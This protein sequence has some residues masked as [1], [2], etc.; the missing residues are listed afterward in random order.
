MALSMNDHINHFLANKPKRSDFT[1]DQNFKSKYDICK[2]FDLLKWDIPVITVVGTNGKGSCVTAL[3]KAYQAAGYRTGVMTSPHIHRYNERIRVNL[4]E[5]SDDDFCAIAE[6]MRG[7]IDQTDLTFALP[8][9]FFFIGLEYFKLQN[10]DVLIL[11]AGM[12][13]RYDT[14]NLLHADTIIVSSISLDHINLLGPSREHIGYEK[15]GVFRTGSPVICGDTNPPLSLLAHA[16]SLN[17]PCYLIN[18]DFGYQEQK[19]SWNWHAGQTTLSDLP[20]S[21]IR[22][23]N[24]SCVLMCIDLLKDRLPINTKKL[25]YSLAK[26]VTP[27]RQ[28]RHMTSYGQIVFDV[29]HNDASVKALKRKIDEW[30]RQKKYTRIAVFSA[31]ANKDVTSM[32][33]SIGSAFDAWC[34]SPIPEAESVS[35]SQLSQWIKKINDVPVFTHNYLEDAFKKALNLAKKKPAMIVVFGSFQVVGPLKQYWTT[36]HKVTEPQS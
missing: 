20:K 3:E 29:A 22:L 19:E 18:K 5:I 14:V 1:A 7:H 24:L 15:A 34:L 35:M 10:T 2:R 13:G 9:W 26:L 12:G 23:D 33:K 21:T 36:E 8:V 25:K 16:K 32:I 17:A 31:F 28:E 6:K 11:E 30:D 27:C 4:T